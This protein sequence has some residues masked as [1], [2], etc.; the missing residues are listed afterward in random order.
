MSCK[1][2]DFTKS[3]SVQ[4]EENDFSN[5][6]LKRGYLSA[7]E[8][9]P[10]NEVERK[11]QIS[12]KK[13]RIDEII[14]TIQPIDGVN[15]RSQYQKRI[16][17]LDKS[18]V[19]GQL[20][21]TIL[22]QI[23]SRE[24]KKTPN[25]Q[26]LKENIL[27]KNKFKCNTC[28]KN[29]ARK[30]NL[31][32]HKKKIHQSL[33]SQSASGFQKKLVGRKCEICNETI[34]SDLIYHYNTFHDKTSFFK[35]ESC[36]SS[37]LEVYRKILTNK[38]ED[39]TSSIEQSVINNKLLKKEIKTLLMQQIIEKNYIKFRFLIGILFLKLDHDTV[40]DST[41]HYLPSV[42]CVQNLAKSDHLE[43][44][45]EDMI[46]EI[47]YIIIDIYLVGSGWIFFNIVHIDVQIY[48]YTFPKLGKGGTDL[49][50]VFPKNNIS[51]K[52]LNLSLANMLI[53]RKN[54]K[55]LIYAIAYHFYHKIKNCS[56]NYFDY[57]DLI[58]K[59]FNLEGVNFP[60]GSKDVEIFLNQNKN[61][62]IKIS[63]INFEKNNFYPLSVLGNGS[64]IIPILV[65]DKYNT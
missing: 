9:S 54:Q 64:E 36:F 38:G 25:L 57:E 23:H 32:R 24:K 2:F 63:F 12:M 37:K 46:D 4:V 35:F 18:K 62:D 16:E 14:T 29:F 15:M 59:N 61:L 3:K 21:I 48:K 58:L 65:Y 33:I 20:H 52:S 42:F 56:L 28:N 5:N 8:T 30:Y 19:K 60:M 13:R 51:K 7:D 17:K 45:I 49:M 26:K 41:V 47:L 31:E 27:N 53:P 22:H 6:V 40:V 11:N 1:K 55:C 43:K 39:S 50:Q 10:N 34:Y 44:D